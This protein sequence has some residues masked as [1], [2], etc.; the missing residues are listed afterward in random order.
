MTDIQKILDANQRTFPFPRDELDRTQARRW[1]TRYAKR[2]GIGAEIGVFRGH[3]SEVL[4][5]E[6][7]PKRLFLVDAW[8]LQGSSFGWSD[9]YTCHDTL[10]PEFARREAEL[11]SALYPSTSVAIVKS[12]FPDCEADFDEQL[13]WIY[14]DTSHFFENTR[15]ELLAAARLIAPAGVIMGDDWQSQVTHPHHGVFRAVTEFT[16]NEPF[17]IVAAGPHGQWCLRRCGSY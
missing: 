11:R 3:F 9:A 15:K 7:A 13:D 8:E 16:K 12:W 6:L 1:I 10:T 2:G 14:L 4:L 5:N 17:E